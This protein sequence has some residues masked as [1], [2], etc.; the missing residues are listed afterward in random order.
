[1]AL[2]SHPNPPHRNVHLAWSSFRLRVLMSLLF[3]GVFAVLPV[4]S[5]QGVKPAK[6]SM[7]VPK[8]SVKPAKGSVTPRKGSVKPA[9]G[10]V[11]PPKGSVKPAKGSVTPRKGSVK[12]A[13]GSVT[14]RKGSVTPPKGSVRPAKGSMTRG[15][16]QAPVR[17]TTRR[18]PA[19]SAKPRVPMAP[20][21]ERLTEIQAALVREGFLQGDPNGKWDDASMAAMK[22]FQVEHSLPATGKI[23]ALSLIALGLGPQRGPAPGTDSVLQSPP[24]EPAPDAPNP[25][26]DR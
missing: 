2:I 8:G 7:S 16:K 1:M 11:T 4:A 3:L 26:A 25:P 24:A 19:Q 14:P 23:N 9:K 21:A 13:K 17:R 22:R 18:Q 5:Q 15:A 10:S 6:G 12:P 20:S